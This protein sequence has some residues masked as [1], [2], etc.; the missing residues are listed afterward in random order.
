MAPNVLIKVPKKIVVN[1]LQGYNWRFESTF[2]SLL[3]LTSW[4]LS[5]LVI[6]YLNIT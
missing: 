6:K 2:E 5:I 3:G 1:G 4:E